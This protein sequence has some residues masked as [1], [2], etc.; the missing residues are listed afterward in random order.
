MLQGVKVGGQCT[1]DIA[2]VPFSFITGGKHVLLA[3]ITGPL[4]QPF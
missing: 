3:T 2:T 4:P 1:F